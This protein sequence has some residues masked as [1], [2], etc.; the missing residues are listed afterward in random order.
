MLRVLIFLVSLGARAIRAMCRCRADL[1]IENLALR[2]QVTALK[3]ERPR[4]P[5]EDTDRAFWVA[6]RSSWP[7]WASRLVIVNADTVARWNRDRFHR[8][9]ARISRPRYPGRPRIDAEIRRLVRTM[10]QDGW[11]APR[12]HAELTKLGFVVSEMTVSRYMPRRRAE[13][14]EVK[15]WIAF[16]RNHKDDIAAMDLFAVPTA[17]LR[18]LYGFF[19]IEHGRRHI[20]HF[21]AT[22]NP[23][24]AWV[25]Q[26][27]REAFPYDTAPRYLVFD[28]DAIFSPTVVEF[29]RAM[30]TKPVRISYRSPWQNGTAERWIGNCRREM[31][32]HV[33]VLSERHLVRLMRLY[34]SLCR[35]RH[36]LI[37]AEYRIM[38]RRG[39]ARWIDARLARVLLLPRWQSRRRSLQD[40]QRS[41]YL[42][43]GLLLFDA[44]S[45]D[46][47][48]SMPSMS[49][50]ESIPS[51]D[52]G[53]T[54]SLAEG[55]DTA[56]QGRPAR[57]GAGEQPTA[58]SQHCS[59]S[60]ARQTK[61]AHRIG[62]QQTEQSR[63]NVPSLQGYR[64]LSNVSERV[65]GTE[66]RGKDRVQDSQHHDGAR[67]CL[68]AR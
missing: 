6:L 65:G 3:K 60:S 62:L 61:V 54:S 57:I 42:S 66:S 34:I 10:V 26:Q 23:T 9:W 49:A 18:L 36:K 12:I 15:R 58:Q 47:G 56:A 17:S 45:T 46:F 2:Q 40:P 14:D 5:L 19:V 43:F 8:Y 37:Y 33:V 30:S 22:Y 39:G 59:T 51:L 68:I 55:A 20:L 31:L 25:I 24:S 16:L 13:P 29:I 32:E 67:D 50:E 21:N 1:V 53:S 4:P 52:G 64:G 27:L 35:Y 48:T 11:G 44:Y 28:R 7:A 41:S 38:P 63:D